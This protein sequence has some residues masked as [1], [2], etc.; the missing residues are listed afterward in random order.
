MRSKLRTTDLLGEAVSGILQRPARTLLTTFGTVLGVGAFVAVLGLTATATGQISKR[1]TAQAATEVTVTDSDPSAHTDPPFPSDA[2]QRVN[3]INGVVDCGVYWTVPAG[4]TGSVAGVPLPGRNP[5]TQQIIAASPG[6]LPAS[7]VH[8]ANG[9]VFDSGHDTRADHVAVLGTS[10]AHRLGVTRIE[11]QPAIFIG[12]I[13]FTVIGLIDDVQRRPELL[14]SI[15]VPRRTA[16]DLW[17]H[18]QGET[19]DPKMLITT[20][21]GAAQV[22]ASQAGLALRPDAPERLKV[23]APPDPRSLQDN[24]GDDLNTLFLILAA[25]CLVI[26]A[27]GIANTTLVAVLERVPEIGLR[28]ALGARGRHVALQFLTESSALGTLGGLAGTS[29]GIGVVVTV[30]VTRDWTP[31]L[32]P[33]AVLP[34]PLA[35]TLVGLLAGVYPALRAAKVE[36]VEA[37]RR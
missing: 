18:K 37:L 17:P 11:D 4:R 24:I 7:G 36:P 16:E 19:L 6:L 15:T 1:F 27:V 34:A 35:G 8:L 28:R 33:W 23:T 29:L 13:P 25:V 26:G 2:E 22:V 32:E 5:D 30:A 21:L 31:V 12:D 10:V 9:R 20:R 14:L 3:A